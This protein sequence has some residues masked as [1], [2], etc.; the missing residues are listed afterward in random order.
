MNTDKPLSQ[1]KLQALQTREK[2]LTAGQETFL[3]NGFQKTTISQII[4]KAQ[5]GYGTAYVYFRNKDELFIYLM[6]ELMN[7]FYTIA[8]LPFEP[9]THEEARSLIRNQ[10]QQFLQLSIK[11]KA[12]M[13]VIQEAKGISPSVQ[14]KWSNIRERFISR[15]TI[16]VQYAQA[17]NLAKKSLNPHLVARGWFY[18]NEM[19]MWEL[20]HNENHY[21]IDDV[22]KNMT[23]MYV[24][25]LYH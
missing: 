25:G 23:Q 14:E 13:T 24:E 5:T 10:V 17:A 12:M 18:A 11:E 22:I 3:S 19:F 6:E 9:I 2:L 21:S 15:I 20:V 16:D 1:R 7:K 4:K 8:E